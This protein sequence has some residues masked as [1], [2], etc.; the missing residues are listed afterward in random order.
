MRILRLAD[1]SVVVHIRD[2]DK[3]TVLVP[4]DLGPDQAL[5]MARVVLTPEE[6][7]ALEE[8]FEQA[9]QEV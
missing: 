9:Y 5:S 2:R 1:I 6:H 4:A 8:A 3:V 7:H